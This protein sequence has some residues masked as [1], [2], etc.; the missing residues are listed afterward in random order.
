MQEA[1]CPPHSKCLLCCSVTLTL[2]GEVPWVPRLPSRP[3]WVGEVSWVPPPPSRPGWGYPRYPAP[4]SRPGRGYL[5]TPH[6]PDLVW[7]YPRHPHTIKTWDG[8]IPHPDLGWGTSQPDLR[9][10]TPHLDLVWGTPHPDLRWGTPST[11]TWDVA[12]PTQTWDV[13]P[14]PRPGM[15]YP[16]TQT[17]D[18]VPPRPGMGY[19]LPTDLGW[20]TPYKCGQTENITFSHPSDAGGND[21]SNNSC[22]AAQ[23]S[24][25]MPRHNWVLPA[26]TPT[27]D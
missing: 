27:M 21:M 24:A 15:G 17:W 9:W 18:G 8:V 26:S 16:P 10:G 13:A 19:P 25:P 22:V 1:H 5:G 2:L 3:G 23:D 6:H 7:G 12:P 11:Q 14:P 4:L 20:G